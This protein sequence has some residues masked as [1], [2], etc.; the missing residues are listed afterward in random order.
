MKTSVNITIRAP[1]NVAETHVTNSVVH[2][3][4][5]PQLIGVNLN[6]LDVSVK[7]NELLIEHI[8]ISHVLHANESF[9]YTIVINHSSVTMPV[10]SM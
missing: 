9:L 1:S 4:I 6:E 7:P 3:I 10:V 5:L 2:L 8:R